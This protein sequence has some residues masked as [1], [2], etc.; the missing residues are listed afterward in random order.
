MASI[1]Q[2]WVTQNNDAPGDGEVPAEEICTYLECMAKDEDTSIEDLAS[3]IVGLNICPSFNALDGTAQ[4]KLVENLRQ[5]VLSKVPNQTGL[6]RS[7]GTSGDNRDTSDHASV[8]GKS[9]R[10][11]KNRRKKNGNTLSAETP[12]DASKMI[13]APPGNEKEASGNDVNKKKI[14]SA[15]ITT[16]P[17]TSK[18]PMERKWSSNNLKMLSDIAPPNLS[19]ELLSYVLYKECDGNLEEAAIY[20]TAN[21]MGE[22]DEKMR[23]AKKKQLEKENLEK[24]RLQ[25]LEKKEQRILLDKYL[26]VGESSDGKT[27]KSRS[28][29]A[30]EMRRE[31][32]KAQMEKKNKPMMYF[33][34]QKMGKGVTSV[35]SNNKKAE[36]VNP[37]PSS[38]TIFRKSQRLNARR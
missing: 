32:R 27:K 12:V 19:E 30:K 25:E 14:G 23:T 13:G 18:Q 38:G 1:V 29:V 15:E 31:Q 10:S 9:R 34:G 37:N 26:V 24:K 3:V 17:Y 35:A 6:S 22:V 16:Q 5:N 7:K 28:K 8:T 20:V 21:D 36:W 4:T 11:R 33:N 2:Q